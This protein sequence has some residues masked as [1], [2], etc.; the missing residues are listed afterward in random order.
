MKI[1]GDTAALH[2]GILLNSVRRALADLFAIRQVHAAHAGLCCKFNKCGAGDLLTVI[3]HAPGQFQSRLAFRRVIVETGQSGAAEQFL[4]VNPFYRQEVRRQPVPEGDGA[5]L[6]QD[7]GVHI[8]AGF[9][10]FAGHSDHIEPGDPVHAGDAD[11]GQQAADGGGDQT[12]HQGNQRGQRQLDPTVLANGVQ[13]DDH[14]E[15]DDSQGDQQG[16]QCDLVGRLFSGGPLHQR[17]HPVQKAVA[18]IGGNADLQPVGYYRSAAGDGTEV[19]AALPDYRSGF[20]CDGGFVYAGDA[21]DDLTIAG[22]DLSGHHHHHIALLQL[23][24]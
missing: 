20:A 16:V 12:D 24:G 3:P 4:T 23:T 7:H 6:I 15:E 13:G 1:R 21:L 18:G 10:R 9:H 11:G 2:L 14:D 5:G 19:A 17:D 8:A 22:D